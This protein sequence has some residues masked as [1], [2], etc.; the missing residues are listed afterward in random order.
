MVALKQVH[1]K[2]SD[3][4]FKRMFRNMQE[5]TKE[6]MLQNMFY[7]ACEML[8]TAYARRGFISV[9]GN[10]INSFAVGIY[11]KGD[12]QQI[13]GASNMGIA[14]AKRRSLKKGEKYPLSKW[15]DARSPYVGSTKEDPVFVG[16]TG[17]GGVSGREAA[18]RKLQSTHPWKRDT[19][20]IIMVAPMEYA[21]Y[22][23][24]KHGHDVL[25]AVRDELPI[26]AKTV[27]I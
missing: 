26:L 21:E 9:T 22:V 20:A 12:L 18:I 6:Q 5:F 17:A 19:Y 23:Q 1:G 3:Q 11:Y 14:Q 15:Y 8:Q 24:K 27:F 25:T 16:E 4:L 10:L 7:M 13:V 2:F